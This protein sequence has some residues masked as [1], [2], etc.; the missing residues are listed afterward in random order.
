MYRPTILFALEDGVPRARGSARSIPGFH[1][2]D[3]LKSCSSYLERFGG[4][5]YA[6]GM[7][8]RPERIAEFRDALRT[9]AHERL[10]PDDLVPEID[11]DLEVTLADSTLDLV[12]LLR[13]FGPFGVGNPTPVFV[14][15]DVRLSNP[16][17]EVG[18]GHLKL[19]LAQGKAR[20]SAIGFGMMDRFRDQD[21]S[22]TPLD[23]AYTLQEHYWNGFVELQA[24]LIDVRP[25]G[26]A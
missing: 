19:D 16:P 18:E 11:Y 22:S 2:Y 7:D 8:I 10:T 6:A 21:L 1:L 12:R 9:V 25:A 24:R 26:C 4:H 5:K 23:V 14:A 15:R 13:H 20:L 17:R 3:A